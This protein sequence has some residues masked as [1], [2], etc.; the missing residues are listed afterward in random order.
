MICAELH[1]EAV[2]GACFREGHHT[3]IVDQQ[4]DAGMRRAEF[5]GGLA[6]ACQRRQIELLHAHNGIGALRGQA[7]LGV[8]A[9]VEVADGEDDVCALVGQRGSSFVSDAGVGARD[10]DDTPGLIRNVGG[11]PLGAHPYQ[12]G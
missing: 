1:L 8:V 7:G 2:L 9:L 10:D 4:V 3:G 11:G 6:H 5:V 12:T